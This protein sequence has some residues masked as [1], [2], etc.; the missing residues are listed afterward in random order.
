MIP[1]TNECTS[2][3]PK[4]RQKG[5][6]C[7]CH[8]CGQTHKYN[9]T[10]NLH[11]TKKG[12]GVHAETPAGGSRRGSSKPTSGVKQAK[13]KGGRKGGERYLRHTSCSVTQVMLFVISPRWQSNC[14]QSRRIQGDSI[15]DQQRAVGAHC[16]FSETLQHQ[17]GVASCVLSEWGNLVRASFVPKWHPVHK[18]AAVG[19]TLCLQTCRD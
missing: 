8:V 12:R 4:M 15:L 10:N 1:Q 9:Q 2:S 3:V 7:T 11:N 19:I 5:N 16:I 6:E 14:S 17:S 13:Q 18:W